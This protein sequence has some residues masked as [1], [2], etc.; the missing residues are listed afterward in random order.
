VQAAAR[1]SRKYTKPGALDAMYKV[2][3]CKSIHEVLHSVHVMDL[4]THHGQVVRPAFDPL[5]DFRMALDLR[6]AP[7]AE[8]MSLGTLS[9]LPLF[10]L[11]S[12]ALDP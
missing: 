2:L 1:I 5:V 6:L 3:N 4:I 10:V 11:S 8:A 9:P 12:F 7:L